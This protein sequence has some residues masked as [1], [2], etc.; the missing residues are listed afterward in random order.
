[1]PSKTS[2][3]GVK[4]RQIYSLVY[5]PSSESDN[6]RIPQQEKSEVTRG[7]IKHGTFV[8]VMFEHENCS[9]TNTYVAICQTSVDLDMDVRSHSLLK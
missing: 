7:N 6:E 2:S 8:K 3:K 5:S 9:K 1:M 4:R